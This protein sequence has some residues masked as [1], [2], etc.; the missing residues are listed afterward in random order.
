MITDYTT[1]FDSADD[2]AS[3]MLM[4][5]ADRM[6]IEAEILTESGEATMMCNLDLKGPVSAPRHIKRAAGVAC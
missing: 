5:H 6:A 3:H 2:L 4:D 1:H